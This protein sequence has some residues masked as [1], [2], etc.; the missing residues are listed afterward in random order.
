MLILLLFGHLGC[1]LRLIVDIDHGNFQLGLV[2][3]LLYFET[4]GFV[5]A[6][7]LQLLDQVLL[8]LQLLLRVVHVARLLLVLARWQVPLKS[9]K[10]YIH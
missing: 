5:F 10:V 9:A 6:L 1:L 2:W 4:D 7:L 8:V 3:G